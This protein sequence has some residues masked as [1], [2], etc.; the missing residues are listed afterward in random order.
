[1]GASFPTRESVL[2]RTGEGEY[3]DSR[4]GTIR[5][6]TDLHPSLFVR[7]GGADAA[8]LRARARRRLAAALRSRSVHGAGRLTG[9]ELDALVDGAH[10]PD[11]E[12]TGPE[13]ASMTSRRASGRH[14]RRRDHH[15]L[16]AGQP[17]RLADGEEAL[18]LRRHPAD[19]LN[20]AVLVDRAGDCD[21]LVERQTSERREERVQLGR[22][23]GITLD[24]VVGLL[25]GDRRADRE[26]LL[27][28]VG[29]PGSRRGSG[30]PWSGSG[31]TTRSRARYSGREPRPSGTLRAHPG[32]APERVVAEVVDG[33]PV[34]RGRRACRSSSITSVCSRTSCWMRSSTRLE[35]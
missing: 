2:E 8:E 1:M 20:L 10:G 15:T 23:G 12:Q 6:S 26:R 9:K 16:L 32:R 29:R 3:A 11:V 34:P 35:R 30:S 33:E 25:E 24:L 28:W 5:E 7:Y 31:Q 14:V 17:L 22:R 13:P 19:S 18:D 4:G 27:V 21:A